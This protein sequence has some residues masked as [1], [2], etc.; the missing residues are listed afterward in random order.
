MKQAIGYIRIS[1]KD[2][3]NFS[4]TG[5]EQ[6]IRDFCAK[7]NYSLLAIFK[8][9]GQSA[10]NFDRP[11][12]K[13][14]E[15]FIQKNHPA[16]NLLIVAKYD[17]FSRNVA[18]ALK[19]IETLESKFE[20]RI[21][22]VMEP[23]MLHPAS[24]YF[25]Q[26][27]TQMLL[28]AQVE[29]LIIR[30]RTKA[31]IRQAGLGGRYT[32]TAPI[33]YINARDERNKPILK[34]DPARASIIKEIFVKF[35][36]GNSLIELH[37]FL[38]AAGIK[39][40]G[41]MAIPRVLNQ[42]LYAG[43][44]KV[45]AYYDEP[46]KLVKGIHEPIIDEVTWWKAQ[47][48]LHG[49]SK[50]S[51]SR[52][53]KDFPLRGVLQCH[54]KRM[55]TASFST[56]K[57][58]KVPYYWCV[59]HRENINAN[60]IHAQFEGLI[61]ELSLPPFY[62]EYLQNKVLKNLR[63]GL[64]QKEKSIIVKEKELN[65]V[66]QRM[67]SIEEK[68]ISNNLDKATFEKWHRRSMNEKAI[69]EADILQLRQPLAEVEKMY[70]ANFAAL[71]DLHLIYQSASVKQKH[72]FVQLVFERGLYY[73]DKVFRTPTL[74]PVF[75][76]KALMLKEKGLLIYEQPNAQTR[77][78]LECSPRGDEFEPLRQLLFLFSEIKIA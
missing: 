16:V 20:I 49:K 51:K 69:L 33:G 38:N 72:S 24:P 40:A 64:R 35:L 31:G 23:I 48:I 28:G 78:N 67:E 11:D 41:K 70:R 6:Y 42:C 54:C 61:K 73:H 30:D 71:G 46:G 65:Q 45:S 1:T 8:D 25:F 55:F 26:F 53:S 29:W 47:G 13:S 7:N 36:Q 52:E 21:I 3:S 62:V 39:R 59:T 10:K 34:I 68:Y 50:K 63:S 22:S 9:E 58:I 60:R 57:T 12:W 77:N 37:R 19:M 14:L 43:L 5:Q 32:S 18:D 15:A 17:R 76:S 4:L 66:L 2:Q 44:V 27:R 56:G 75:H 74:M